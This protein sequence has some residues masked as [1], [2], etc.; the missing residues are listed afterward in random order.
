MLDYLENSDC[1]MD[2]LDPLIFSVMIDRLFLTA[3]GTI[4]IR[5]QNGL[6]VTEKL[7]TEVR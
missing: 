5:L 2:E 4:R 1:W 6:E 7:T 3:D